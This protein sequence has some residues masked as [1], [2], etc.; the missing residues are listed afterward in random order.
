MADIAHRLLPSPVL[1]SHYAAFV[2]CFKRTELKTFNL[3]VVIGL[4][5][6]WTKEGQ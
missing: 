4:L 2:A 5:H 6:C 1:H 3:R